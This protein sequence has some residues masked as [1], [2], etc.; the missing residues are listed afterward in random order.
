MHGLGPGAVWFKETHIQVHPVSAQCIFS[1][2]GHQHNLTVLTQ[3]IIGSLVFIY[4]TLNPKC[5]WFAPTFR[6]DGNHRN[7]F[8]HCHLFGPEIV[9]IANQ[10]IFSIRCDR[11]HKVWFVVVDGTSKV[12][13]Q[14]PFAFGII[15]IR[16]PD[17]FIVFLSAHISRIVFPSEIQTLSVG[18]YDGIYL[19]ILAVDFFG[20]TFGGNIG[21]DPLAIV[22]FHFNGFL[23]VGNGNKIDAVKAG[24]AIAIHFNL[25]GFYRP[26]RF[27]FEENVE[28]TGILPNGLGSKLI[29]KVFFSVGFNGHNTKDGSG[30]IA[31]SDGDLLNLHHFFKTN[32]NKLQPCLPFR[33]P[34]KWVITPNRKCIRLSQNLLCTVQFKTVFG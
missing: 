1:T 23:P 27:F 7:S 21:I 24:N 33:T 15:P 20:K 2:N 34:G 8:F 17:V 29:N 19:I 12:F 28:Q 9:N 10:N 3:V 6:S 14:T 31:L 16:I 26:W 22:H 32:G 30:I 5:L 18:R 4:I 11:T 13:S 25:D